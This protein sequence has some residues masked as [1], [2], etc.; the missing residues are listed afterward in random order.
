MHTCL[1][2]KEGRLSSL[3]I[4]N[5]IEHKTFL[6]VLLLIFQFDIIQQFLRQRVSP[7]LLKATCGGHLEDKIRHK[8]TRYSK[9]M[10]ILFIF[11]L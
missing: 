7:P 8:H 10:F 4:L 6:R 11:L 1:S 5:E 2:G 3:I 9:S